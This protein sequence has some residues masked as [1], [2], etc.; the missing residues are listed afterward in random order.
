MR[1]PSADQNG[2]RQVS[3]LL[4]FFMLLPEQVYVYGDCAINPAP[5]A[6]TG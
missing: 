3:R 2:G 4:V 5:T 6:G 1:P